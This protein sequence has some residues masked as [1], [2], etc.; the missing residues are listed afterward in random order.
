MKILLVGEY[1]RLHNSLKEGLLKLGHEVTL[2]ATG[3]GF[4]DYP[5]DIKIT[6]SYNRGFKSMVKKAVYKLTKYDISGNHI[7][8]QV[9]Q[10][11]EVLKGHD[12]VQLINESPFLTTP[13][14]EK[15]IIGFLKKHN[16]RLFLLS[17][18]TDYTSVEYAYNKHFRY[19]ILTPYFSGKINKKGFAHVLKYLTNP[20]KNLHTFVFDSIQGVIASDMDYHIPLLNH[21]KYLGLIPNPVNTD[22][23]T[24]RQ[25][26]VKEKVIIFHGINSKNYYKKGN[27]FFEE[28]LLKVKQQ[29]GDK[30]EI[31]TTRDVPYKAYTDQYNKAHIVLDQVYAFDQGYNALEAMAKGKVVFTGAEQEWLN[32][33]GLEENTVAI[34]AL[35]DVDAI[36]EKLVWLI[37]HPNKILTLSENARRFV[38]AQ[39]HYVKSAENYLQIWGK[40]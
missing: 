29:Y 31:I 1:S 26:I 11:A 39:H 21:P 8:K 25:P 13:K 37:E 2:I 10:H 22:A 38:E 18:G 27:D 28:A 6:N 30:I 24:Y 23:I 32:Y 12:V 40:N 15:Q 33:Y 19:S 9:L 17:C 7:K 14:I 3:D 20:F 16:K 35:P 34:N 5:A 4:K 36:V